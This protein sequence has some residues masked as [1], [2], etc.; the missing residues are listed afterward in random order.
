MRLFRESGLWS[1]GAVVEGEPERRG[2]PGR[3][4]AGLRPGGAGQVEE[5]ADLGQVE[6]ERHSG[7]PAFADFGKSGEE[8]KNNWQPRAGAVYDLRGDGRDV[9]RFGVGRYYD[10]G[11]KERKPSRLAHDA[12][13]ART[14]WTRS[15]SWVNLPA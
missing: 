13:L 4:A 14:L 10:V 9:L 12:E 7:Q 3:P 5:P 6:V 1:T 2:Q 8:D 15:A 11:G